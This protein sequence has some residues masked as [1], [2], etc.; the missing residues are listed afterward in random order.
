MLIKNVTFRGWNSSSSS[1][2]SIENRKLIRP[3]IRYGSTEVLRTAETDALSVSVWK[4]INCHEIVWSRAEESSKFGGPRQRRSDG[5][6]FEAE[7]SEQRSHHEKPTKTLSTDGWANRMAQFHQVF[8]RSTD[9]AV[10]N[11][12]GDLEVDPSS[13]WKPVELVA[14]GSWYVAE[15]GDVQD[16]PSSRVQ[17]GLKPVEKIGMRPEQETIAVIDPTRNEGVD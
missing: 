8:R 10:T 4:A 11:H 1:R 7:T 9:Q 14:D 17:H 15:L 16:Q 3:F 6:M 13:D 2:S 12:K 5:R